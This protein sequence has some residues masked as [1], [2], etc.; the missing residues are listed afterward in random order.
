VAERRRELAT[1]VPLPM[2]ALRRHWQISLA[3]V[4]VALCGYGLFSYYQAL[5]E[6]P[7]HAAVSQTFVVTK[8][9]RERFFEA[10]KLF[11][12]QRGFAVRVAAVRPDNEH[13][14]IAMER[15]DFSISAVN[16]F[17]TAVFRVAFYVNMQT[18]DGDLTRLATDFA[19]MA[20]SVDGVTVQ[21]K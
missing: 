18:K 6:P 5:N 11:G 1:L 19:D 21:V 13:F 20:G 8:D 10:V 3:I 17:D 9:A 15:R 14:S 4:L 7:K 2:P 16:P 12:K